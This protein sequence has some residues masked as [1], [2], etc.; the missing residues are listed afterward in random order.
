[1]GQGFGQSLH[2]FLEGMGVSH[3][4]PL[5]LILRFLHC[6]HLILF[7]PPLDRF[8]DQVSERTSTS[9]VIVVVVVVVATV[10][11]SEMARTLSLQVF[12]PS[13]LFISTCPLLK[14]EILMHGTFISE[15]PS[16]HVSSSSLS[17]LLALDRDQGFSPAA[18]RAPQ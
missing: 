8:R 12:L 4:H 13:A 6:Q 10:P 17:L 7:I 5:Q 18:V 1:M 2:R 16:V 3:C 15:M 14:P 9:N 11:S